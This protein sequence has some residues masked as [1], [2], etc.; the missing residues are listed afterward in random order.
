MIKIGRIS[1]VSVGFDENWLVV[2]SPGKASLAHAVHE[3]RLSP[4]RELFYRYLDM[5]KAGK[6]NMEWFQRFYVPAFLKELI[7][8]DG[9]LM[10]LD[11]LYR[12]SFTKDIL[13]ACFCAEEALC[14][15]S[16]LAGMLAG[17][18]AK[19]QCDDRYLE[20]Y[21]MFRDLAAMPG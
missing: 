20:Y 8:D 18:G 19:I 2:R 14:H 17:A 13:L 7:A 21:R 12:D 5:K 3:P 9:S 15:R 1:D 11:R 6:F 10:L 16:I 4:S